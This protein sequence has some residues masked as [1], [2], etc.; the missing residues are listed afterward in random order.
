MSYDLMV[1]EKRKAP[2]TKEKF[3]RWYQDLVERNQDHSYDDIRIC[4]TALK[5]WF[6]E[7]IESFPAMNGPY[8]IRDMDLK[9]NP[10]IE[11]KLAEY[12]IAKDAIYVS[13]AYS[14]ANQANQIMRKL[15]N[16]HSVGFFDVSGGGD[17][18]YPNQITY[19]VRT[20]DKEYLFDRINEELFKELLAGFD[21][22]IWDF[23]VLSPSQDVANSN[24][25]QVGSPQKNTNFNYTVEIGINNPKRL[26]LYRLYTK[27]RLA[28]FDMLINYYQNQQIPDYGSWQDV[29]DHL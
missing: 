1:F 26:E 23:I 25:I 29:S 4:S 15:A 3:M 14:Q 7:M 20:N 22:D 12:S 13:F 28:V 10:E 19:T 24:F 21:P 11:N 16:K 27:D 18:I 17:I 6:H 8:A 2:K 5:N 9:N